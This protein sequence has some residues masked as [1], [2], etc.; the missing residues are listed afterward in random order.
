MMA[1]IT[2]EPVPTFSIGVKEHDFN[3]LPFARMVVKKYGLDS[4]ERVVEAN[5]I[6]LIPSMIF[7]MDEPS[8]PFGMGVYLVSKVA[9][10]VVKVALGGDGGDENFAGY[11]RFAGNQLVDIYCLLPM[12]FRKSVMKKITEC[13]PES[14]TYK[15]FAQKANWVNEMSLFANGE[16][17][18]QSMSFLR[19]TQEAK[20]KLFTASARKRIE[21]YDSVAKILTYFESENVDH[22]VDRM[23]Y[24]DLM[25]R[26][27]DHLL[28]IVDRMSMAHSLESRSPLID[29]RVVEFAASIPAEMKLKR[30]NLKYILKKVAHRYLP[31]E[32]INR[33][34]QG[35]GFPLGIWMR[36]ELKDFLGRLFAQSR[37]VQE[38]IFNR[39]YITQ[40]L[41]E[42]GSGK[43]NHDF[44]LW[45]LMNLEIW[46]KMYFENENVE[47]MKEYINRSMTKVHKFC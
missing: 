5:A 34:K 18:A 36:K 22:L 13:I 17:Y 20:E 46:Y 24:T 35:F 42:H 33:E 14:F 38:G 45:I 16:R 30:K 2:R 26:M 27:P 19:F 1:T 28:T 37:F 31:E 6:D 23:L 9:S 25:T 41:Q 10:E 21:D 3:E 39:E 8:D 11:D 40:L 29:Y 43:A 7:H 44:R 12:W 47:S 4:H 15:S 32:L